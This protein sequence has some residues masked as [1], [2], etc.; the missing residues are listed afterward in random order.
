M[1]ST[2]RIYCDLDFGIDGKQ[3]GNIELSFSNNKHNFL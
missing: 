1:I 2:D 3:F